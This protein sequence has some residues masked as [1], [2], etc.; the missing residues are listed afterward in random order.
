MRPVIK[1]IENID[2]P[3]V[4]SWEPINK[5][6]FNTCFEL[7]I[8]PKDSEGEE[9]FSVEVCS[10]LWFQKNFNR[11]PELIEKGFIV[12]DKYNYNDIVG[13]L[14][15]ICNSIEGSDWNDIG[16][17]LSKYFYWEFDNYIEQ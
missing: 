3:D 10:H 6:L 1:D 9:I 14:L 16:K 2:I 15:E 13:L 11:E 7:L 12:V 5:K 8:G 17:Q 4:K